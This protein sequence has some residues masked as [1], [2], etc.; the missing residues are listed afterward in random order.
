MGLLVRKESLEKR[1]QL[2]LQ[3]CLLYQVRRERKG[4]EGSVPL[5]ERKDKKVSQVNLELLGSRE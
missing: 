1:G 4:I 2:G 5:M 3:E